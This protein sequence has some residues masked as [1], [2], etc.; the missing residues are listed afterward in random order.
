[1]FL[2]LNMIIGHLNL[3]LK[4]TNNK[5]WL[6]T[7]NNCYFVTI[8]ENKMLMKIVIDYVIC[9]CVFYFYALEWKA[10]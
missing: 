5:T 4:F 8:V 10:L 3:V 9:K 7:A 6:L 2:T 1:M